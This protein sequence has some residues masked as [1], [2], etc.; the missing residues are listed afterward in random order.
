[1]FD[2]FPHP[3]R[4]ENIN[5]GCFRTGCCGKYLALRCRK[6]QKDVENCIIKNLI[7]YTLHEILLSLS[8]KKIVGHAACMGKGEMHIKSL[9]EYV[10]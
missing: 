9:S 5:W 1:V 10:D 3:K 8:N 2:L 7:I 4:E 6:W